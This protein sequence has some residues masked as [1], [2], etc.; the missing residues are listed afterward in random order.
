MSCLLANMH[1]IDFFSSSSCNRR[2]IKNIQLICQ[3]VVIL[4]MTL[5]CLVAC[6][7]ADMISWMPKGIGLQ[8]PPLTLTTMNDAHSHAIDANRQTREI[9]ENGRKNDYDNT[10][11]YALWWTNSIWPTVTLCMYIF[12][13]VTDTVKYFHLHNQSQKR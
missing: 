9:T 4:G 10:Q 11:H 12:A 3:S 6:L 1:S 2:Q 13:F 5:S 7:H 8:N